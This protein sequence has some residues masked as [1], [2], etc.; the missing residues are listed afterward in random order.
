[1]K[2]SK[3]LINDLLKEYNDKLI[4]PNTFN[5]FPIY[6]AG[7]TEVEAGTLTII[8]STPITD[9]KRPEFIGKLKLL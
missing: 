8:A 5:I 7:R 1:M 3:Q 2:I 9:D 4:K 6:D